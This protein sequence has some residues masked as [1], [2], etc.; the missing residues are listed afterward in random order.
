V[1]VGKFCERSFGVMFVLY[2]LFVWYEYVA[3]LT[4]LPSLTEMNSGVG[5]LI[6]HVFA[7]SFIA[8]HS[9]IGIIGIISLLLLLLFI[10]ATLLYYFV[11]VPILIFWFSI[12]DRS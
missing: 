10:C 7:L 5:V 6:Q 1:K 11:Y 12:F 9:V 4:P 2:L 3:M 8:V